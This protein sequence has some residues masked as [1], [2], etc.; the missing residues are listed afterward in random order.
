MPKQSTIRLSDRLVSLLTYLT[1]GWAGLIYCIILFIQKKTPSHFLRYN[2]F[3]SIFV[4]LLYFVLCMVLG[5]VSNLLLN[6]PFINSI[7]SW[8]IL[9]FN[10]PVL[11]DYSIVQIFVIGLLLYMSIVSLFGKYPRIYW[12]SKIIDNAAQ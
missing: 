3:Q 4:S 1:V 7:I 10:R 11:F 9:I 8:F 5:F 6:I 2:V 12:V